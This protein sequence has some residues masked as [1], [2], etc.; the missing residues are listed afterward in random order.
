MIKHVLIGDIHGCFDELQDLLDAVAPASDDCIVALGDVVD[1]GPDSEKALEFLRDQP[2]AASLM[3]N[4]ERKHIRSARGETRPALSQLITRSQLGE[5]YNDWLAYMQ[6]FPRH[7]ELP[8]AILVHGMLE[9]GIPLDQ[10]LDTVVIGTLT[11]E[12]YMQ[13]KYA[14]PWYEHY[15]GPK[16]VVVG[17]HSHLGNGQPMIREGLVYAI[18]T[19]CVHGGRLTALVLPEFRIVSVPSR[20]DHWSRVRVEY[21]SAAE[22]G[23]SDLDLNWGTLT[24]VA[25]SA[26]K[27]PLGSVLR[28]R[29]VR[30]E[31]I[32]GM[33]ERTVARVLERVISLSD[34]VLKELRNADD[35]K[36]CSPKK[37]AARY[38]QRVSDHPLASLLFAARRGDLNEQLIL[39]QAKSPRGLIE[40]ASQ[41]GLEPEPHQ[42]A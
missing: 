20:G 41:S 16:P 34:E 37:Q 39:R 11:G 33:C 4:H 25:R 21:A 32:A 38:A 15:A 35:W 14:G 42:E 5:R 36:V 2:N 19:G 29:V 9:P 31:Q 8:E 30:C 22:P 24:A 18:D 13:K 23:R 26:D 28:A 1:R 3:G 17:H 12:H 7:I 40:M 10:Q 6:S 27:H